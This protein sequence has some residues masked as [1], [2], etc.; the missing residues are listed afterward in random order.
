MEN[1]LNNFNTQN[2]ISEPNKYLAEFDPQ[3]LKALFYLMA[4][5]PDSRTKLFNSPI[6]LNP[7]DFIE[8]NELIISKLDNHNTDAVVSNITISFSNKEI[9]EISSW[10]EFSNQNWNTSPETES[11]TLQWDFL[12]NLPNYGCP[13]RHTIFIKVSS[14][15]SPLQ[16]MRAVFSLENHEIEEAEL[17]NASMICRI[18]FINHILSNEL[19]NIVEEWYE[20]RVKKTFDSKTRKFLEKRAL[21]IARLIHYSFPFS[22]TILSLAFILNTNLLSNSQVINIYSLRIFSVSIIFSTMIILFLN[23]IGH[24]IASHF[25]TSIKSHGKHVVFNFTNGDETKQ[26]RLSTEKKKNSRKVLSSIIFSIIL[27]LVS[28]FIFFLLFRS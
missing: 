7:N 17:S 9:K 25:F 27:D 19:M 26:N 12:I 13:Q 11:I 2:D 23:K 5:K 14:E 1:N 8:L 28:S 18:N 22:M 20:S 6:N 3:D 15:F 10:N 4:G 24:I 16:L 21:A